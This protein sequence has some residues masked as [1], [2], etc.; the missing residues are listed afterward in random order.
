ML[1]MGLLVLALENL[2]GYDYPIAFAENTNFDQS[3]HLS[4]CCLIDVYNL[5]LCLSQCKLNVRKFGRIGTA[6]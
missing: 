4:P 6:H 5:E 3:F 2:G 1:V